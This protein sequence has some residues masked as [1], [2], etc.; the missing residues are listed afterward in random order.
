MHDSREN[1]AKRGAVHLVYC[2]IIPDRFRTLFHGTANQ[3][4]SGNLTSFQPQSVKRTTPKDDPKIPNPPTYIDRPSLLHVEND[5]SGKMISARARAQRSRRH[6]PAA[7]EFRFFAVVVVVDARVTADGQRCGRAALLPC[8]HVGCVRACVRACVPS[9]SVHSLSALR[10]QC[11][12][13]LQRQAR[14]ASCT[15][16]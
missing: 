6:A 7:L 8:C 13:P 5:E 14:G 2:I 1:N 9:R 12:Q 3:L 4:V 10:R 16:G 15:T 11:L